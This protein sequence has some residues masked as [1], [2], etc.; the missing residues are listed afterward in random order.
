MKRCYLLPLLWCS[1]VLCTSITA[2]QWTVYDMEN[3]PLPSTNVKALVEDG[4]GGLWIGT[5][6]GLCHFDGSSEWTVFQEGTSPLVENDIRSLQ[7]DPDGRLWI[8]TVSMG[9]Q[10]KDG[11]DWTTYTPLNSPLPEYGIRDLDI[12][13][14]GTVWIC[15]ASGLAR[16]DGTE[17]SLYN[18][19]PESHLGAVLATANTNAVAVN[20]DG[21]VCLGTFNGGLHFIQ[22]SSVEVL[23]SFDDGFFDNTAVDV[24]F[25]PI[26]GARWVATPAAG[27]LRQQGP[28][29]GGLWT[30]WSGASGFPSN[31]TTA[32]AVDITGAVWVG[33]QIAGLVSVRPD[34]TIVQY[35]ASN[36]S[37]P[38]NTVRSVL[39]SVDG[40]VWVGTFLGGLARLDPTVAIEERTA[41]PGIRVH[42]NPVTDRFEVN[43]P[44]GCSGIEWQLVSMDGKRVMHGLSHAELLQVEVPG[45]AQGAYA[46]QLR[47]EAFVGSVRVL[48][49]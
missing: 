23:T 15:T 1:T 47:R 12:D 14:S 28:V 30:Q 3:S 7:L 29:V 2:Q 34:G 4:D 39:G 43:C 45:L 11:D 31:A 42:P 18:N 16:F 20:N 35:E 21:T 5:D 32:L 46:L 44:E 48:V 10:V 9:L 17:W 27:L 41:S 8:G 24:L 40:S 36:S 19:T 13:A 38:D 49:D 22:G 37:L 26:T 25:H 33:T 6:W